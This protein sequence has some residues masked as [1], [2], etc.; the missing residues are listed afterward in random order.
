ML[1]IKNSSWTQPKRAL[2]QPETGG[3]QRAKPAA[4]Q[5]PGPVCKA[6]TTGRAASTF[7][8]CRSG[9]LRSAGASPAGKRLFEWLRQNSYPCSS[10]PPL[11]HSH[12]GRLDQGPMVLAERP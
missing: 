4:A 3:L 10:A 8:P 5:A 12:P 2:K 1:K 7:T 6:G 9:W 11:N